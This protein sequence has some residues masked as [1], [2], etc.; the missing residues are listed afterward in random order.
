M[1]QK[2]AFALLK[3]EGSNCMVG[4]N[5]I[6]DMMHHNVTREFKSRDKIT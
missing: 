6:A 5:I 3:G 4:A 1:R 2:E